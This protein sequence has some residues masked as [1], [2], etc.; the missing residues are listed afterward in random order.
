MSKENSLDMPAES[1]SSVTFLD[2]IAAELAAGRV[3]LPPFPKVVIDVQQT[4]RNPNYTL[5]TVAGII[6]AER[7]LADRLL[8]MANTTAFNA[9]GRVIIDLGVAL[10]R[11]GAQKVHS[12]AIAHAIAHIR[13]S[14]SLRAIAKP[15]DELW[16]EAAIVAHFCQAV[17]KRTQL[18]A[19]DAF[20][21][22]LLHGIGRMYI[23]V[24]CVSQGPSGPPVLLSND[25]VDAWHPAIAKAVLKNWHMSAEV[26]DAVGAQAELGVR[27]GP[28]NLT[29]VLIASIRLAKRKQDPHDG[30]SLNTGGALAR[31]NLPVEVCHSLIAEADTD[32]RA[33]QR[34]LRP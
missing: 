25:L 7:S 15:L 5:Q 3:D 29:D 18:S 26:C 8:Q 11:L 14:E 1:P 12:V 27:R 23:L 9:T 30:T 19:P 33:L 28:A 10:T 21:A 34:A 32:I 2:R 31:L 20:V 16:A 17:A 24:Q 6:S 4:F 22:G 13:Q